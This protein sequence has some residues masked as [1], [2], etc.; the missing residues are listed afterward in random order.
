M[1]LKCNGGWQTFDAVH[2]RNADLIEKTSCI[3]P[4]GIE[5]SVLCFG[6]ESC[7]G[8][9]GLPRARKTREDYERVARNLDV[10]ALQVVHARPVNRQFRV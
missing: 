10:D 6:V 1:L 8:K 3:R 2:I 4:H 9:R 7:E 5:I